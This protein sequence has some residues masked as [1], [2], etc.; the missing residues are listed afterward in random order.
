MNRLASRIEWERAN[1][2]KAR[3][4]GCEEA[5]LAIERW[6]DFLVTV[7]RDSE[8]TVDGQREKR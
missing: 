8:S 7:S 6:I 5:A 1:A 3:D 4:V 2:K